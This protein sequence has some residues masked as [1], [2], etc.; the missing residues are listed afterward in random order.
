TDLEKLAASGKYV[1]PGNLEKSEVWQEISEGDMPP[2]NA[3][4]GPLSAQETDAIRRW[5]VEGAP[6]LNAK[7]GSV[8][9]A[10]TQYPSAPTADNPSRV[11]A[12]PPAEEKASPGARA[13]ALL[14]RFHVL[15]VH[16]PLALL[17]TAVSVEV[18][19]GLRRSW[20]VSPSVRVCLSLG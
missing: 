15:V 17:L 13:V 11:A 3:K 4:A 12:A 2:D 8:E 20:S 5:I 6:S 18:V 16:F 10:S 1:V 9:G 19:S 14:G 7:G